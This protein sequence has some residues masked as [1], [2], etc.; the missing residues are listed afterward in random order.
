MANNQTAESGRA[1]EVETKNYLKGQ[2][3][4]FRSEWWPLLPAKKDIKILD[5]GCG[6]GSWVKVMHQ[7]GYQNAEGI[8]LSEEQIQQV[9]DLVKLSVKPRK[10]QPAPKTSKRRNIWKKG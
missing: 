10:S 8:D 3:R 5:I 2:I 1:R 6:F 9:A 4:H 7:A